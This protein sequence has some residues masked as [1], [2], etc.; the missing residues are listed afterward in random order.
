MQRARN[1]ARLTI[2]DLRE[3][4]KGKI[5]HGR[6]R[7]GRSSDF[8]CMAPSA[9]GLMPAEGGAR[10]RSGSPSKLSGV[11][12]KS[13]T[14]KQGAP[15]RRYGNGFVSFNSSPKKT[16]DSNLAALDMAMNSN[17]KTFV[18][19]RVFPPGSRTLQ[20]NYL[21]NSIP[22][23]YESM[24]VDSRFFDFRQDLANLRRE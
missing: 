20:Q 5:I 7:D 19:T 13:D 16:I 2:S 24:R 21:Q 23:C 12:Q 14:V 10:T 22:Q 8:G 9:P 6:S 1:F 4:R 3:K 15:G 17:Q 11:N 18:N